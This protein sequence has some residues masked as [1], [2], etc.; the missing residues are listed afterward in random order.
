M[1]I[2]RFNDDQDKEL[3]RELIAKKPFAAAYGETMQ[4]W[5]SVAASLSQAIGVEVNTKQVRDRLG[6]LKKNLAAGGRLSA[7][8]SG[9]EESLDANDVQSHYD[10]INGLVSEYVALETI[11]L[12]NKQNRADKK[13]RK[14]KNLNVCASEIM[15]ESNRRRSQR[16]PTDSEDDDDEGEIVRM[17]DPGTEDCGMEVESNTECAYS[18]CLVVVKRARTS[19]INRT[20]VFQ[21]FPP[22]PPTAMV[23]PSG[24]AR[25]R[26]LRHQ[27]LVFPLLS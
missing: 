20:N 26:V 9:I 18:A 21:M 25:C 14:T 1:E 27:R 11:H 2:F 5:G 3:L 10:E 15:A 16:S 6:V 24:T 8:G 22:C 19:S 17:S 23:L 13:K 4:S 7:M 12:Q